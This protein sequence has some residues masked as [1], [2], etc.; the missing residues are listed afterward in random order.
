M[1]RRPGRRSM[2]RWL[3]RQVSSGSSTRPRMGSIRCVGVLVRRRG[4]GPGRRPGRSSVGR[5]RPRLPGGRGSAGRC[6]RSRR[7]LC[8]GRRGSRR[9]CSGRSAGRADRRAGNGR[10]QSPL[11]PSRSPR[12]RQSEDRAIRRPLLRPRRLLPYTPGSSRRTAA[13]SLSSWP[14]SVGSACSTQ[15][16]RLERPRANY[17]A[18]YLVGG[19]DSGPSHDRGT[20]GPGCG[21]G[22]SCET[23]S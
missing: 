20:Q 13:C 18:S 12:C 5:T 11:G 15:E 14:Q 9:T 19:L 17:R 2:Q 22:G 7:P 1:A 10:A 6:R 16:S 3:V 21:F 23:R 8:R 4:S